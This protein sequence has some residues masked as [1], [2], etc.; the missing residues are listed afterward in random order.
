MV[1]ADAADLAAALLKLGPGLAVIKQERPAPWRSSGAGR[2]CTD[3]RCGSAVVDPVGAGDAFC[4]GFICARLE[5]GDVP[6]ALE[7]GNACGASAVSA[8]GDLTGMPERAAADRLLAKSSDHGRHAP[9]DRLASPRVMLPEGAQI[10]TLHRVR[11]GP[12]HG[13][14][15]PHLPWGHR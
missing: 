8:L 9:L 3:T 10:R 4:A 15:D 11:R 2:L 12:G 7:M 5:G 14:I 1:E 6:A 13:A